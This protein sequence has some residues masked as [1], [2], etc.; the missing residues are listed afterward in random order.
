[1]TAQLLPHTC[2][3]ALLCDQCNRAI[4]LMRDN[5]ERLEAAAVYLRR[6]TRG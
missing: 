5:P 4:G 6:Y 2:V 3:R 1:M